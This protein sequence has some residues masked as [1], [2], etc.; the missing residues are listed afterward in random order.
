MARVDYD[1]IIAGGGVAGI[2]AAASL[3]EF[4][5]SILIVEPGQHA[6]RRLAGEL[7]HP[8]GVAALTELGLCGV[9]SFDGAIQIKGFIAFTGLENSHAQISLP[10]V[11]DKSIAYGFA[12]DHAHIRSSL[13]AS[14]ESLSYVKTFSGSRVVGIERQDSVIAV[15]IAHSGIIRN[16]TCRLVISADGAASAVRGFA[17][18]SHI[19]R[20]ISKI[21][22]YLISDIN[23][24][25][26]GFGHVFMGS[27]APL[28]VY[29]IGGGLARV[30]FDQPMNQ[31][32]VDPAEHRA[33]VTAAVAHPR[34]RA[35]ITDAIKSQRGLSFVSADLVVNRST[36]GRVALLGDAGGSCHPL[37][38][39]GM[40]IGAA[41]ALRL[42][43]AFRESNGDIPA[44]LKLY[45]IRRRPPQRARL[46]VASALHEACSG[47][48]PESQLIRAGLIRYWTRGARGRQA[49]MAI[50]AMSNIRLVSA[51]REMLIV[52][53]HGFAVPLQRWSFARFSVGVRLV[54]GLAGVV[55]RQMT[56]AMKAR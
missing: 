13:Q 12:L 49:S 17:G 28:L 33:C 11:K 23:L 24:P 36:N 16:L 21:T 37:T 15:S 10:Y 20:P 54:L 51:L 35:E 9:G 47:R 39:T 14:V 43:D 5:W 18:I 1:V 34:L 30:L 22:G 46:L 50:L 4:G 25:S 45:G 2:S 52:I 8:S 32:D 7:I 27:L 48:S 40:T 6:D 41:D 3:K 38:A 42:R 19:R 55:L 31:F 53:L 56:F 29:E 44:G 26:P